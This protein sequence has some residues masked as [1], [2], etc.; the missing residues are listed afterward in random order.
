MRTLLHERVRL[1][2]CGFACVHGVRGR[3]WK[4][5]DDALGVGMQ[6]VANEHRRRR[7]NEEKKLGK[8]N[9]LPLLAAIRKVK[10]KLNSNS[11]N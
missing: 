7:K 9:K 4:R 10:S 2:V 5:P 11:F 3:N 6:N 1:C 8:K